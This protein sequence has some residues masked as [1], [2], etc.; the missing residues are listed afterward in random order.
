M[1]KKTIGFA[2]CGSFCTLNS[3]IEQIKAL[4]LMDINIAGYLVQTEELKNPLLLI[5]VKMSMMK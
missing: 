5:Y 2:L 4:K 1:Q 3:V